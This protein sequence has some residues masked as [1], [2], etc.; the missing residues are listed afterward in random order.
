MNEPDPDR[1]QWDVALAA[2][3]TD[4]QS[5][6]GRALDMAL[7]QQLAT[8]HHIRLDDLLDTLCRLQA[9]G[10]WRFLD[11]QGVPSTPDRAVVK[12]LNANHRLNEVQLGRLAGSWLPD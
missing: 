7:L 11:P 9:H 6:A 12:L 1:P 10:L 5:A 3:L 2:L 8:E 4:T